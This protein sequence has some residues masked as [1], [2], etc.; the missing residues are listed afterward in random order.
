MNAVPLFAHLDPVLGSF[1]IFGAAL[2]VS[3]AA[4]I[5]GLSGAFLLLPFQISV[6]GFTGTSVTPTNHLFNC[7]AIPPGV[8]RYAREKRLVGPLAGIVAAGTVPGVILGSVVRLWWLSDIRSFKLFVGL[9]LALISSRLLAKVFRQWRAPPVERA[10]VGPVTVHGLN[11]KR[12]AYSFAGQRH[13]VPTLALGFLSLAVG[14]IGGAYGVGGGAIIGPF[15]IT[16]FGLPVFTT[17]GATLLGTFLTSAVAVAFYAV[18]SYV[19]HVPGAAPNWFV[20]VLLG[21]GGTVGI[22]SG[23]RLQRYLP[24]RLIESVLGTMVFGLSIKYILDF[25][26]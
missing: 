19:F 12:L 26:L 5:G 14:M 20:G 8:W 25:F 11:W 10:L 6:L 23:A 21:L 16:I 3:L 24:A 2:L 7:I 1:L 17:A 22:Y 18:A 13:E 15:L 9:V 4:S